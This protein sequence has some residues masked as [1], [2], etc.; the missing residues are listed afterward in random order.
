VILSSDTASSASDI[1]TTSRKTSFVAGTG[2]AL[3]SRT[4]TNADLAKVLDTSDEWIT[5]RVGIKQRHICSED[6]TAVSLAEIACKQAM[7]AACVLPTEIDIV[8]FAT[9]TPDQLLPSAAALLSRRLG[10]QCAMAFDLQA[11][12]SGFLFGFASAD[13]LLT[14]MNLNTALVIGAEV[15][16]RVVNWKDRNTA[17]LFGD[18]AGAC[19]VKRPESVKE[20]CILSSH[21]RTLPQGCDLI[22]RVGE[23]FPTPLSPATAASEDKERSNP[24]ID[25]QGRKVFR[26]G[27]QLM[28]SSILEVL[29]ATSVSADEIKLFFPHQSNLRMINAVCENIGLDESKLATNIEMTGNTSAASIPIV[30]DEFNRKGEINEG[31]LILLTAVGAGMTYGSILLRW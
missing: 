22:R 6:E 29:E 10:I 13:A 2:S 11:A 17:V 15:L 12:C 3:P 18:G 14:S 30:L 23:A 25:M 27:V 8:I 1:N 19:V 16:S 28:T 24:Y 9:V 26:S 21:L 5:D 4:L 7:E 20:S 31:D